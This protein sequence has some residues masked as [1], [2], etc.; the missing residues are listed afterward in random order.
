MLSERVK[1]IAPSATFAVKAKAQALRAQGHDVLSFGL[2]QPDF[3]TPDLVK[4]AAKK[5]LDDGFTKY[6]AAAG[7]PELKEA[8][9]AK[10][11]RDNS[12]DC[13][14]SNIVVSN[15]A[16][17][18][19]HN[20]FQAMINPGDEVILLS[21]YWVSYI[22]QVRLSEGKAVLVDC[23]KEFQPIADSIKEAITDKTKMIVVNSP[24]NPTGAV[25][26]K[27]K[28]QEIAD[29]ALE[30]DLFIISD[31]CYEH[32]VYEGAKHYS[33]AS[34]SEELAAKTL[35]VNA[36]SK[37]YAMTGWRVGYVCAPKE[38]AK[39]MGSLQGQTTSNVN[40]IAQ[41]AA[42]AALNGPLD[43][44][45]EMAAT[46][47]ERRKYAVE[48]FNKIPGIE[49]NEPLG[50]FYLFPYVDGCFKGGVGNSAEFCDFL[51]EK[52][53]VGLVPGSAFGLDSCVR[54]SCA[55]S[56]DSI[57]EGISRIAKALS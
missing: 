23:D 2:G 1:R 34:F 5:A 13:E 37:T 11:K 39:A 3:D 42:V 19:L 46:F 49:C 9:A 48:E 6:T 56:L 16:K 29:I 50:A 35:T 15:G 36:L 25:F 18:S 47:D 20:I 45:K 44:V 7:I 53:H 55:S 38:A 57:K 32:F 8:I 4:D 33:I 54:F 22:E 17:H 31:E 43:A 10:L 27:Q 24:N 12:I 51:L 21:P 28:L 41:K 26:G 14:A 40:S 52:A 30:N